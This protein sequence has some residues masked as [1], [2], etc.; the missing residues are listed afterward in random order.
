M[1]S[2]PCC[3]GAGVA[4]SVLPV[5]CGLAGTLAALIAALFAFGVAGGLLDVAMNA[6]CRGRWP[7][8]TGRPA[9]R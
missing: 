1:P 5:A 2:P 3:G 7:S 9:P 4:V 8:G 6:R